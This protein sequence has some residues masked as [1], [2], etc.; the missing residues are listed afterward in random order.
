MSKKNR[1]NTLVYTTFVIGLPSI[2]LGLHYPTDIIVESI[3]GILIALIGNKSLKEHGLIEKI[4]NL[5]KSKPSFF[6]AIFF[7]F[8]YQIAD[9]FTDRY[10]LVKSNI[11][12]F[13]SLSCSMTI[14]VEFI[15]K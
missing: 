3:I 10:S 7:L 4:M 9:L 6:Y 12:F 5:S 8:S 2:Y 11:I 13:I 14:V 1:H 15:L